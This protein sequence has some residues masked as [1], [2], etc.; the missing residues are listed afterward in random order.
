MTGYGDFAFYYDLLTENVDY[1]KRSGYIRDLLVANGVDKGILLDL[2]CGTG[3]LTLLLAQMG[4]DMIGVDASEE[5]LSVAQEKKMEGGVGNEA[6]FLCQKMEQLDLFGTINGA[7]CTLDSINHV[8]DEDSVR[9]IFRRVSLF[10]EDKGIFIFDV[11]TPYKHREVLGDNTFVYDMD[12]VYCVWQ[13]STDEN[14]LTTV[15]LDIFEKAEDE[16]DVFIRYS[17]EFQE[18]GYE[19]TEIRQ[20]LEENKFELLGVY[21]ELSENPISDCSQRAVFVAKK[22]GTQ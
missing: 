13:N 20:W 16:D 5:M 15:S 3:T 19:L 2:A 6:I 18:K 4:Y 11:N 17:E 7:V 22:H 10:M 12:E 21:E 14:L 9:E 1:E 8:T